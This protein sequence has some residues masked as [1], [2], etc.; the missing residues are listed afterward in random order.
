MALIIRK[1]SDGD[2][3]AVCAIEGAECSEPEPY[4]QAVFIRQAG[5][6]FPD[7]FLVAESG[8]EIIGYTIGAVVQGRSEEGW[9]IRMVVRKGFRGRKTGEMMF[10]RIIELMEVKGVGNLFLTVSPE[11]LPACSM[12]EK[13]GFEITDEIPSYFG[14]GED[15][16]VMQKNLNMVG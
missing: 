4:S 14:E 15:R 11:N 10:F 13:H 7:T 8:G 3:S 16:I 6:L 12:Y 1:Y 9:I 5:L 2:F